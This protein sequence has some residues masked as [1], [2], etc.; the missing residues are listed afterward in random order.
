MS[1]RR[2]ILLW[3]LGA[4][5]LFAAASA[6]ADPAV[7]PGECPPV[8]ETAVRGAGRPEQY[9]LSNGLRIVLQE[10][11]RTPRIAVHVSYRVG[12]GDDPPGYQGL[13][14]LAELLMFE[15]SGHVAAGR[16]EQLLASVGARAVGGVVTADAT[17][18]RQDIPKEALALALWLESDRMAFLLDRIDD[19]S[20]DR[21]RRRLLTRMTG[22]LRDQ[23]AA[24]RDRRVREAMYPEGHPYRNSVRVEDLRAVRA[25]DV[26]WFFQAWYSPDNAVLTLVGDFD[27]SEARRL[28][29]QYFDPIVCPRVARR[30]RR[31]FGPVALSTRPDFRISSRFR[32][33]DAVT[34]AWATPPWLSP[35]DTCLDVVAELLAGSSYAVLHRALV[36]EQGIARMVTAK[37]L[38]QMHGSVFVIEVFASRGHTSDELIRAVDAELRRLS[39]APP[40]ERVASA[41][42]AMVIKSEQ[43]RDQ[44]EFRAA[45]IG[46]SIHA[47]GNL[48]DVDQD[49]ARYAAVTFGD[50]RRVIRAWLPLDRR[51][52]LHTLAHR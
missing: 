16:Y 31:R 33:T 48:V 19:G 7:A 26:Q 43:R 25:A 51:V 5:A 35:E 37:Q 22:G 21:A 14:R 40:A 8:G 3:L 28:I 2:S 52:V 30:P 50:V 45:R 27:R 13:S 23:I 36:E 9:T 49:R 10:D 15:G 18:Y 1:Q 11:H 46:R 20:L 47:T 12:S 42:Y 29:G 32:M 6:F 17:E 4:A 24:E 44:I 39:I 41:R 38:S 34:V